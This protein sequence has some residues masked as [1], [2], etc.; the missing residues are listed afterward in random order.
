MEHRK[1]ASDDTKQQQLR[2]QCPDQLVQQQRTQEKGLQK[3]EE[4]VA[5]EE[6]MRR[7]KE[8]KLLDN[9]LQLESL[10]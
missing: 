5:K 1:I 7:A 8:F 3:Q 4:N 10:E 6:A 9:N 2:A